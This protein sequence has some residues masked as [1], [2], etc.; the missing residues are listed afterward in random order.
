MFP[1]KYA[2]FLLVDRKEGVDLIDPSTGKW[3][4]FHSVRS[5]KWSATV[6]SRLHKGF[7]NNIPN[8]NEA[9]NLMNKINAA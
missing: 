5:A 1:I 6:Y 3:Q 2:N 7:G 9:F 4:Q 8:F